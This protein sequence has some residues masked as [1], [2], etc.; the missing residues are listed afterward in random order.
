LAGNTNL[1]REAQ[2]LANDEFAK[3]TSLTEEYNVKNNNLA[4]TLAKIQKRLFA[5]WSNS[6]IKDGI[7]NFVEKIGK[8]IE[9]PVAEK[10]NRER[11]ETNLL[12]T[13]AVSLGNEN[14]RRVE[15]IKQLQDKYPQY[16]ANLEAEKVSNKELL[17]VMGQ[18][19]EEAIKRIFI[20]REKEKLLEIQQDAADL[21]P[22]EIEAEKKLFEVKSKILRQLSADQ[23]A[24]FQSS[25]NNLLI[26]E[27]LIGEQT[28]G[29]EKAIKI[30]IMLR[31]ANI[32]GITASDFINLAQ[33]NREYLS[34]LQTRIDK[35]LEAELI[36]EEIQNQATRFGLNNTTGAGA[37][38]G[39]VV[40]PDKKPTAGP[41][42]KE[43]EEA[44]KKLLEY[45]ESKI[46]IEDQIY[47][48]T[49]NA[50]DR[51]LVAEMQKWDELIGEA[52]A[53]GLDVTELEK[54]RNAAIEALEKKHKKD[55]AKIKTKANKKDQEDQD[56]W[57]A[58]ELAKATALRDA[59]VALMRSTAQILGT[60]VNFLGVQGAEMGDFQKSLALAQI[61]IDTG[62]S[63]SA[64]VKLGILSTPANPLAP[65]MV[66]ANIAS[67]VATVFTGMLGAKNV[68]AKSNVP[69][70]T[71]RPVPAFASGTGFAPGG[72]SLVGELGPELVNLPRGSQ[73]FTAQQSRDIAN[74]QIN[75]PGAIEA[76]QADNAVFGGSTQTGSPTFGLD[77]SAGSQYERQD[78]IVNEIRMLR[79]DISRF[80]KDKQFYLSNKQ[81]DEKRNEIGRIKNLRNLN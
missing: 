53:Y 46:K 15:I 25:L 12:I 54:A 16:L 42:D 81:F 71:P 67:L 63:I 13:E 10:L 30:G 36:L 27:E 17:S 28:T 57:D 51:E 31:K 72:M 20:E 2:T 5:T 55:I 58:I 34:A 77:S 62:A 45:A 8:F 14:E 35:E 6:A 11:I 66:A 29:A 75:V 73:V 49:L 23:G 7:N 24:L 33:Y 26:N 19:N 50:T 43:I 4:G 1:V 68:L 21:L 32:T 64:A 38:G 3:A 70:F 47:L 59:K 80:E 61:A 48:A 79:D 52:E 22:A 74:S 65:I 78:D 9:M 69:E 76:V 44:K 39:G 41:T 56:K 18:I 60:A 40:D 37:S